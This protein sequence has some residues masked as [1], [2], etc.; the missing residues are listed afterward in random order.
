MRGAPGEWAS[1]GSKARLSSTAGGTAQLLWKQPLPHNYRPRFALVSD[2]GTVVLFDQWINVAGPHA[3]M[4]LDRTGK[5][6][7]SHSFDEVAAALGVFEVPTFGDGTRFMARYLA[8]RVD[9]GA[10]VVVGGG[11]SVAAVQELGVRVR[12]IRP[13][14]PEQNG[15]VER[16]H[17]IDEEEFWGR[18]AGQDF[19]AAH[20][21]LAA[22]EHRYNHERF[23]MALH[24]LTPME[25]LAAM[26]APPLVM[27]RSPD[28]VQ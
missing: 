27:A 18:Y 2:E 11:D 16:S 24:G 8:E 22:W 20:A 15:K 23:S 9:E 4:V 7:A 19:D 5:T 3:V 6:L 1:T 21:A 12:Y 25:K 28:T 17:R 10:A 26:L 14:R 13:R